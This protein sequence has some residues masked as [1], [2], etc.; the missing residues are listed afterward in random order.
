MS[1]IDAALAA[2]KFS[3]RD[4]SV[5]LNGELNTK[6]DLLYAELS[7]VQKAQD[8]GTASDTRLAASPVAAVKKKIAVLEKE[9][10]AATITLRITAV[11]Y[12]EYNKFVIQNPPRKGHAG[13]AQWGFNTQDFFVFVA[14][15]T[16][17]SVED[18]GTLE[19][20]TDEQWSRIIA[21]L[22]D[23]DHDRIGA[24]V[25]EVNRREGARGVDFLSRG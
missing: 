24:A 9:M 14:K 1:K 18:D 19:D 10:L 6:R 16:S 22:T 5:C 20:I 3:S 17:K 7:Q 12:G 4:V 13:D 15:R 8:D 11:P 21:S 2:H 23:G 25:I